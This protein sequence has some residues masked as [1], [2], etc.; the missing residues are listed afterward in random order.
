MG[1]VDAPTDLAPD[2]GLHSLHRRLDKLSDRHPSSPRYGQD[3][4]AADVRPL[5]DAEHAEHVA[6][7]RTRLD[8]AR[9]AGLA[10]D[11]QHT[12]DAWHEVWSDERAK[13]MTTIIDDL[14]ARYAARA[15]RRH[16]HLCWWASWSW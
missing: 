16:G 12:I 14:Y 10:T 7:V 9:K 2:S 3:N 11:N 1:A 5:T 8:E 15:V 4:R 13:F 6:F